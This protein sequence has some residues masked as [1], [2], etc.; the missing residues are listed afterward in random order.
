LPSW[1][2]FYEYL[3]PDNLKQFV[4]QQ[5]AQGEAMAPAANTNEN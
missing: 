3:A 2:F 5:V 1:L 4:D